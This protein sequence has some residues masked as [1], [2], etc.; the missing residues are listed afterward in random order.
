LAITQPVQQQT[1]GFRFGSECVRVASI[2][3][4]TQVVKGTQQPA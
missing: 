1:S 4:T 3:P 2:R